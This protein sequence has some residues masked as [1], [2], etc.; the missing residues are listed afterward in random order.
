MAKKIFK[1]EEIIDELREA[2]VLTVKAR[3]SRTRSVP[4]VGRRNTAA[5]VRNGPAIDRSVHPARTEEVIAIRTTLSL[6]VRQ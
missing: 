1:P 4:R 2:E 5:W 3:A 6:T